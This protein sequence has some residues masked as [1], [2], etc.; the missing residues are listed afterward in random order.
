MYRMCIGK[1]PL[2]GATN[3]IGEIVANEAAFQRSKTEDV[4]VDS[5]PEGGHFKRGDD[6]N[7]MLLA[8][9]LCFGNVCDLIVVGDGHHAE[10]LLRKVGQQC[11]RRPTAIAI[12]RVHL[13]VYGVA[14]RDGQYRGRIGCW[15]RH[16]MLLL[17]CFRLW[18][19]RLPITVCH[20]NVS[21]N[22]GGITAHHSLNGIIA[23]LT[24]G[25]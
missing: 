12:G 17:I 6:D 9:R 16:D 2:L 14:R 15:L 23:L 5:M 21:S 7:A 10:P 22:F 13:K 19:Y 25:R 8:K 3:D 4:G 24:N 20:K 11:V 18:W 1:L